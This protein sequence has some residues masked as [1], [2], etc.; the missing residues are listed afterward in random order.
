MTFSLTATVNQSP[1][2]QTLPA[3]KPDSSSK[4]PRKSDDAL[5]PDTNAA[6]PIEKA[7]SDI[8]KADL[9]KATL[10]PILENVEARHSSNRSLFTSLS[11]SN[12]LV[13][14]GKKNSAKT[15]RALS[16]NS[17][18]D[19]KPITSS[20]RKLSKSS[21]KSK[22]GESVTSGKK[23]ST[24]EMLDLT[25]ISQ[26]AD[27]SPKPEKV[28]SAKS[29]NQTISKTKTGESVTSGKKPTDAQKSTAPTSKK[30][31]IS[32]VANIAQK[33][34]NVES[35]K[36]S[37]QKIHKSPPNTRTGETVTNGKIV[38]KTK[39]QDS[40]ATTSQKSNI[41]LTPK[42]VEAA[43]SSNQNISKSPS[44][45]KTGESATSG[46]IPPKTEIQNSPAT[47]SQK[48]NISQKPKNVEAAM[49]SNQN[50]SKS[51]SKTKTGESATSGKIP[52]KIEVQNSTASTSQKLN[53][54]P[55]PENVESTT[56]SNRTI[57]KSQIKSKTGE[58][59][60]S[61]KRPTEVQQ[62]TVPTSLKA[63]SS[64]TAKENVEST[65]TSNRTISKSQ[66]KPKT[67]ETVTSGGK[68]QG[69]PKKPSSQKQLHNQPSKTN[70]SDTNMYEKEPPVTGLS[71]S[72][73]QSQKVKT[74]LKPE[75]VEPKTSTNR[76]PPKP[77]PKTKGSES[78][79][80]A[81][82]PVTVTPDSHKTSQNA[83]PSENAESKRMSK[84]PSKT[85]NSKDERNSET[86]TTSGIRDS[87]K[88]LQKSISTK[89]LEAKRKLSKSS[90]KSAEVKTSDKQSA[91]T[92][93]KDAPTNSKK[94]NRRAKP[95]SFRSKTSIIHS[96]FTLS[97][98][99]KRRAKESVNDPTTSDVAATSDIVVSVENVTPA[100]KRRR[101][102]HRTRCSS[103]EQCGF[104]CEDCAK[105]RPPSGE[106]NA[107]SSFLPGER[108]RNTATKVYRN[109]SEAAQMHTCIVLHRRRD[110][111]PRTY[112]TQ[113]ALRTISMIVGAYLICWTP[114]YVMA[115][116]MA[117]GGHGAVN[118][119]LYIFTYWLR[120]INSP[121]NPFIYAYV[122]AEFRRTFIRIFQ[123]RWHR[124]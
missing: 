44:K 89:A 54:S 38:P 66:I 84:P 14:S 25:A 34:E 35:A 120:Y 50:I 12:E 20:Q 27:I 23:P 2:L 92:E 112:H 88:T 55:K 100:T 42:N 61:G 113:K 39:M 87:L 102:W 85:V 22:P 121:I 122:N 90:S 26:I 101:L 45:T 49:S 95:V 106:V 43:T 63:N 86:P 62:L 56:T 16:A 6:L 17:Q 96:F 1:A 80:T 98:T 47:T 5:A 82:R 31:D 37:N 97:P 41:S 83:N 58:S 114:F 116:A 21:S 108:V 68:P 33:P 103:L 11:K 36:S 52:P 70:A 40:K 94:A 124:A 57:S 72:A 9:Q 111:D 53:I 118:D 104:T 4:S 109:L 7:T 18:K 64:N 29:S 99:S 69:A 46:K 77:S 76:Q 30:A 8:E 19:V 105:L 13:A 28:E 15:M 48:S 107:E 79:T 123:M 59:V 65:T 115:V 74:S 110:S 78:T 3:K 117:I 51:P 60:T 10:S 24:S 67:G 93:D 119:T 71:D 32:H 91:A 81:K 73:K 75:G